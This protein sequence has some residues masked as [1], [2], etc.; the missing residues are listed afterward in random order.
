MVERP[1]P[2]GGRRRE[3]GGRGNDAAAVADDGGCRL[4]GFLEA[5]GGDED[6]V[7]RRLVGGDEDGVALAGVD[8]QRVVDVLHGVAAVDLHELQCV[9]LNPELGTGGLN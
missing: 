5:G 4:N 3:V 6:V 1:G 8:V 2:R 9:S 7:A